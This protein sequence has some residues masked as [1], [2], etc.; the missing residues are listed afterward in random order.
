M[1]TFKNYAGQ[2]YN[3]YLRLIT[4]A[5]C[6]FLKQEG[7]YESSVTDGRDSRHNWALFSYKAFSFNPYD[8][9]IIYI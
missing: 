2:S 6:K 9:E 7:E 4:F 5:K 8:V 1:P 3:I